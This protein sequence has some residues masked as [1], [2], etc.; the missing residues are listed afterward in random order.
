MFL[1][2]WDSASQNFSFWIAFFSTSTPAVYLFW[3][4]VQAS[5]SWEFQSP[6]QY[7]QNPFLQLVQLICWH[8]LFFSIFAP[9]C[10]QGFTWSRKYCL[11]AISFNTYNFSCHIFQTLQ[12]TGSW[13][14]SLQL[15]QV[16]V[17]QSQKISSS[18]NESLNVSR[19]RFIRWVTFVHPFGFLHTYSSLDL[20]V[21]S[22]TQK[23]NH[24]WKAYGQ[25]YFSTTDTP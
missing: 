2:S 10:G 17:P 4:A 12:L 7:Q 24:F 25:A 3:Y 19:S 21:N 23:S 5:Q 14:S 15:I 22:V 13:P 11:S 1:T 20:V 6:K 18:G 9:Q 16:K 8:P